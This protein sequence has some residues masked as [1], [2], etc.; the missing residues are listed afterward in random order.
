MMS[1]EKRIACVLDF[2]TRME[3]KRAE[4]VKLLMWEI[5]KNLKD[6]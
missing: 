5:G 4:V 6:S 3:A 2:T 1:L